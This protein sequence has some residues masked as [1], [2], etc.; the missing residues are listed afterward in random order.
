M[1]QAMGCSSVGEHNYEVDDNGRIDEIVKNSEGHWINYKTDEGRDDQ[2]IPIGWFKEWLKVALFQ[3]K[4]LSSL[5][6]RIVKIVKVKIEAFERL[7]RKYDF[8][9]DKEKLKLLYEVLE[10]IEKV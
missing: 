1:L 6:Q 8:Q 5:K 2:A 10:E 3:S 4:G 9:Q 7:V